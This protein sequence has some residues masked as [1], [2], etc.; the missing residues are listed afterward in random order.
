MKG[1]MSDLDFKILQLRSM[2]E[3]RGRQGEADALM[4]AL[5]LS[6]HAD[7][8]TEQDV[9]RKAFRKYLRGA[10]L[11]DMEQKALNSGTGPLGG[12]AVPQPLQQE[13]LKQAMVYSPIRQFATVRTVEVGDTYPMPT[14]T[15]RPEVAWRGENEAHPLMGTMEFGNQL[16]PINYI[17]ST[18]AVHN[19]L[20][21]HPAVDIEQWIIGSVRDAMLVEEGVQFINGT[22]AGRPQ[23]VLLHPD[24][25]TVNSGSASALTGDGLISLFYALPAVHRRQAVWLM[26]STTIEAAKKLKDSQNLPLYRDGWYGLV[27]DTL[28]GRPVVDCPDMPDIA[29]NAEPIAFGDLSR[30]FI[31]DR[32]DMAVSRD[33]FSSKPNIVF[34]CTRRVGGQ[35]ADGNA[36]RKQKISA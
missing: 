22:G 26:N 15:A 32:L 36:F 35:L 20:I 5:A 18:I 12:Y 3:I 21:E 29:A 23:G 27:P 33:E 25:E 4:D 1:S 8:L 6:G 7:Q 24:V 30:Y 28:M 10:R 34:D 14:E 9:R 2:A 11:S 13:I 31:I 16:I 17:V 19:V